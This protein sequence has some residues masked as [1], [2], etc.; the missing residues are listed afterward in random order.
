MA[1]SDSGHS[2]SESGNDSSGLPRMQLDS[3]SNYGVASSFAALQNLPTQPIVGDNNWHSDVH[4]DFHQRFA[5]G[6]YYLPG[7]PRTA[8]RKPAAP[9]SSGASM[10]VAINQS[11]YSSIY[12]PSLAGSLATLSSRPSAG[13]SSGSS[14]LNRYQTSRLLEEGD[15]GV[16]Q[17]PAAVAYW[18]CPFGFLGCEESLNSICEW[19]VHCQSHF[20]GRDNLP[21][22]VQCPFECQWS[23]QGGSGRDAWTQRWNHVYS[24]H[25]AGG[26][27]NASRRPDPVLVEH[28]WRIGVISSAQKKDLRTTGRINDNNIYLESANSSRDG[29]RERR[30]GEGRNNPRSPGSASGYSVIRR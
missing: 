23:Y 25:F 5:I 24:F 6:Q 19:D 8:P 9:S 30:Q 29:R 7:E 13:T 17:V 4:R 1:D 22:S 11:Q 3:A 16:L 27:I 26:R 12:T 14:A 20:R 2:G 10:A 21:K 15:D 28:L 18:Q